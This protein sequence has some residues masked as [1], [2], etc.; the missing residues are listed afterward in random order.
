MPTDDKQSPLNNTQTVIPVADDMP[1][2]VMNDDH[3]PVVMEDTTPPMLSTTDLP[4]ANPAPV[5]TEQPAPVTNNLS[6]SDKL[7][8]S[9]DTSTGSAAPSDDIVMAPVITTQKKKFAGGKVIAT[10]L[11]LFL[12]V[13]GLGAGVL[14]VGQNQ[15]IEERAGACS[16]SPCGPGMQCAGDNNGDGVGECVPSGTTDEQIDS[17]EVDPVDPPDNPW[18]GDGGDPT[19]GNNCDVRC[20][21]IDARGQSYDFCIDNTSTTGCNGAAVDQ[22]YLIQ[23]GGGGAGTGGW[24]CIEG[25]SGSNGIPYSGGQCVFNNSVQN[26]GCNLPNCFCGTIQIDNGCS[27]PGTYQMECGCGGDEPPGDN[28]TPTPPTDIVTAACQNVKAYSTSWTLLT[29]TQLSALSAGSQVN[30]C[31][32]GVATGGSFNKAK[33]AINSSPQAE[34]TT[35]RPGSEDFCQLYTIP[36]ATATFNVTAQINHVTLGWK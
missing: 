31:V 23:T 9:P 10:I 28:P 35:K 26:V 22:G 8:L 33:F 7:D 12:L 18:G 14:L 36:V 11:G 27:N 17:G 19:D 16:A 32:A 2:V 1:P 25:E 15:N 13:G 5:V 21:G 4:L 34:T 3:P 30:F 20:Q 29:N 6:Q 24:L